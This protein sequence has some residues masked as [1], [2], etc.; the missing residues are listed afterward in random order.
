MLKRVEAR[1]KPQQRMLTHAEECDL[2]F[3]W[4]YMRDWRALEELVLPFKSLV[5]SIAAERY[6]TSQLDKGVRI[7]DLTKARSADALRLK[8]AELAG[9]FL[10]LV[11]E[12]QV[13]LL[14]AADRYDGTYRFSTYARWW[15]RKFM[16]LY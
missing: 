1:T 13:G 12:G 8:D 14:E 6:R 15:V 9:H 5:Y 10:E 2:A 3:R 7:I 4:R 11:Q 16:R